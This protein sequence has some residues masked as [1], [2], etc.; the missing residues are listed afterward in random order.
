[1]LAVQMLQGQLTRVNAILHDVTDDLTEAEWTTRALPGTN[2][3]AFEVWHM[4]RAQDWAV[5]TMILGVPEVISDPIWSWRGAL[6]TPGLGVGLSLEQADGLARAV[7][8]QDVVAYADAVHDHIIAW[9][10][11][12]SDDE[13]EQVPDVAAHVEPHPVYQEPVLRETAPWLFEG[14]PAWHFLTRSC[15]AHAHGHLTEA[16]LLKQHLRR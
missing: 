6:T 7:R 9:L 11:S 3:L 14:V 2:L 5:H 16:D 8:R 4:V 1:V 15:I 12:V 10:S 13:L